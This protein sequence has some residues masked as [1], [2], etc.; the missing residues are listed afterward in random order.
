MFQNVPERSTT[1]HNDLGCS[2]E[3]QTISK[4]FRMLQ[5]VLECRGIL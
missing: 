4:Y 3:F 2:R 5:N 1:F